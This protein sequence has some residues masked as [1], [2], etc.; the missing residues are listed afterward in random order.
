MFLILFFLPQCLVNGYEPGAPIYALVFI[1]PLMLFCGGLE[2]AGW[3]Y[4][5]QPE[6]ERKF[7]FVIATLIVSVIW[8]LW[9]L[10]LFFIHGVAQY[11]TNYFLF[12]INVLALSFALAAIRKI[13]KSVW[14]C[15]LFHCITN[16]LSG[17]FLV[18]ENPAG[19][20]VSAAVVIAVSCLF[21]WL[22]KKKIY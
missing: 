2:E 3:R 11:G 19:N 1:I 5:L 6:L 16:A 12:G 8:W 21:V 7:S 20:V 18:K 10:P 22:A 9:H 13:T 4:V 14:L 15:V 17:T